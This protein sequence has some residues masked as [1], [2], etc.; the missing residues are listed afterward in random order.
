MQWR[1][2]ISYGLA[3]AW[4][5]TILTP[6]LHQFPLPR[7][8]DIAVGSFLDRLEPFCQSLL[9]A[10][11]LRSSGLTVFHPEGYHTPDSW[12]TSGSVQTGFFEGWYYKMV[13][14]S[15]R[16]LVAIPGIIY[17]QGLKDGSGG[18]A[19]VM[20]ADPDSRSS[21]R[22]KLHQYPVENLQARQHGK[23]GWGLKIG[24]QSFSSKVIDL[25]F[26]SEGQSILGKVEMRNISAWPASL[27]LP[28]VMG[29]FAWLPGMEC[30]HGV[31]SLHSQMRGSF[32]VNGET[33]DMD[34]GH[35]YVEKDW[36]SNFPKTWVWVQ[37]SH[38]ANDAN[39]A[40]TATLIL[41]VA[42]IP[43][44]SDK[45]QIIRFRGFL[46]GLWVPSLGGLF[47]FATYTGAV[48]E[49]L[50]TSENQSRV[51]LG[52]RSA[53]YHLAVTAE[54][55]RSDAVL[56]HGP[57]PG[58]EFNPFVHEMLDAR[59]S[60]RLSRRSD[61]VLLFEGQSTHG[62]LEIESME[63]GGIRLLETGEQ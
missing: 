45:L 50:T 12:T 40:Q 20:V 25:S 62:G 1:A 13:S 8:L 42:S 49:K 19:F 55:S 58:G 41:S 21:H 46:G 37:A 39:E 56:L 36:G 23:G 3:V 15:G 27:L 43:F 59:I 18:F 60:V 29:W 31:V 11:Q 4:A 47:R 17:G 5:T 32:V 22:V 38:F 44:P 48:V 28:D 30:R 61:G 26:Q 10:E 54:G 2:P 57:T 52:I 51:E 53:Q 6:V 33:V 24:P 14:Q 16:T 35:A 9:T 63:E 34:G 7:W